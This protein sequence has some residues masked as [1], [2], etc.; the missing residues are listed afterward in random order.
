[1]T[2]QI[3]RFPVGRQFQKV[4]EDDYE[5]HIISDMRLNVLTLNRGGRGEIP[6]VVVDKAYKQLVKKTLPGSAIRIYD[7]HTHPEGSY[8]STPDK[9]NLMYPSVSDVGVIIQEQLT[10]NFRNRNITL[11]GGGVITKRG[12]F[13]MRINEGGDRKNH[14]EI[15]DKTM[16]HYSFKIQTARD[17]IDQ[18]MEKQPAVVKRSWIDDIN[19]RHMKA[20][21]TGYTEFENDKKGLSHKV[22][23]KT[24]HTS[25]RV[26]R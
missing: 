24:H 19:S 17:E 7:L 18:R 14:K 11:V 4:L 25:L 13:I 16:D 2:R 3:L 26:R 23:R 12:I 10:R 21:K 8:L 6:Y 9:Y 5:W 1:M 22:I 15:E 20:H